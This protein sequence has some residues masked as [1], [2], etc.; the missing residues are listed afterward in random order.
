MPIHLIPVVSNP[1]DTELETVSR[2]VGPD[3]IVGACPSIA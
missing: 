3:R 2:T 1:A